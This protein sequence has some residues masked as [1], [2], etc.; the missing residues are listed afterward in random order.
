MA[1]PLRVLLVEDS[2]DDAQ[3]VLAELRQGGWEV[4][5]EQVDTPAAMNAAL[6]NNSWD[7]IISDYSLPQF[8]GLDALAMVVA[9][10]LDIP[11]LLVSGDIEDEVAVLAM[12]AGANDYLFK[13]NLSRLVPSVQREIREAG[14]RRRSREVARRLQLSEVRHRRLFETTND[15]I[16]ILDAQTARVL[17]VNHFMIHLVGQPR[18]CFLGKELSEIGLFNDAD[19]ARAAI[20]TLQTL[21]KCRYENLLL[22][23]EEGREI[24]IEFV[25]N[26]YDED[27][28]EMIQ[29]NI[30]DI[31]ARKLAEAELAQAKDNAEAANRSKSE[32]L[33]NISHEIRTP[34]NAI[35]G[36]TDL[37]LNPKKSPA[38]SSDC[39]LTIRRNAHYLL[40][41]I[42]DIL[43]LSK[44]ESGKMTIEKNACDLPRFLANV[45]A[46]M[47]L[48]ASEKGL[49]FSIRFIGKIPRIIQTDSLKFRQILV[50]LVGNAIKFT[51]KGSV[52][53]V[54]RYESMPGKNVLHIDVRDTGIGLTSEELGRLF[55][56][57][58]QADK[59]TTR[60]FGGTGLGLT[61]SRSLARLLGGDVQASSD[62]GIGSTFSVSIDCGPESTSDM[63]EGL[64]ES[65]LPKSLLPTAY[66]NITL[67]GRILLAEDGRDNQR[68][69][70]TH[71]R[72]AGM[73]V[74]LAEN[75]RIAVDMAISQ[76]F[77]LILMDMQMPEMDGYC[78]TA[79]L[80][81][82]G[83]T[84]PIVALTANAM[85]ED[86]SKCLKSGCS[87]YLSKPCDQ[88]T[89]LRTIARHLGQVVPPS[90]AP[91]AEP[92][93]STEIDNAATIFSSLRHQPRMKQII[94]E[95]VSGLEEGSRQ[96]Q[97]MLRRNELE[98]L[99]QA[100]HR[101]RGAA[102]GYGFDQV[103][104]LAAKAETSIR[105]S[106]AIDVIATQ[107]QE[108][109]DVIKRIDGFGQTKAV[110]AVQ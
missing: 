96:M 5:H 30:R 34:M 94:G 58:T 11:F 7:V 48:R 64:S 74:T 55:Q 62:P 15:G 52:E 109:V 41:I 110:A 44:V 27:A 20:A 12:K 53:I 59:S 45:L 91:T 76:P 78:A 29:C 6:D 60:R 66:S 69:L 22:R 8:S 98:D 14:D 77:D 21:G 85:S 56:A 13:N 97:E 67:Q 25:G 1:S 95:F 37:M 46:L 90:V 57:F 23:R 40:D 26:V 63:L 9:K 73:D 54:V 24:P 35:I 43:D 65:G 42:N 87:D 38:E 31:T 16:L 107:T 100:I 99:C 47:R 86:R 61:I 93:K 70:T 17:E 71:L 104:E 3:L 2:R 39:L 50:N 103:T 89:L 108:L 28:V 32:F 106:A 92:E 88:E 101:L 36:F 33:A 68:L 75:G 10:N 83:F 105:A 82:R 81:R 102:G 49:K 19:S 51:E 80:R 84:L 72:D 4:T 79:E 18:E